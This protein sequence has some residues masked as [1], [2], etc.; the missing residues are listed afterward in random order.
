MASLERPSPFLSAEDLIEL[1]GRKS[2]HRQT[3]WLRKKGWKFEVN[4]TGRPIVSRSYLEYRL[5]GVAQ[6]ATQRYKVD[7]SATD[8][9]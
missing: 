7:L 8:K 5:G 2:A 6:P 1:T 4:A 9:A 3:E